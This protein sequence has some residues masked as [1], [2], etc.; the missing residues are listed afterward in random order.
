MITELKESEFYKCRGLLNDHG[1][2][3]ARA[4]VEGVNPGRVFVDD[5]ESPASGLIWLG[6]NDGFIFIGNERN[7]VFNTG[8]NHFIDTVIA[9]EANKVGLNWFEGIG[10]HPQWNTTIE[11]VFAYRR[12]GSWNQRVYTLQK[13]DYKAA[14]KPAFDEKYKV[15][16]IS[17][18]FYDKQIKNM[19]FLHAKMA[20]YGASAESFFQRGTGYCVVH[21]NKIVSV[22]FSGFVVEQFH[23]V[24]IETLEEHRGKKLA[25]LAAN[26]F[27]ENCLNHSFVPYWDCMASN[28]PSIAVAENIGFKNVFN[29]IGYEFKFDV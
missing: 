28:K 11:K 24:D 5:M 10:N 2:L 19:D 14:N 8:L 1:Q 9:P 25:Q 3:E 4:I 21:Q 23:C 7:D 16:Q 22:C 6:N 27:V 13:D 15:V 17:E 26:A 12:L 20:E 29:Y 18:I